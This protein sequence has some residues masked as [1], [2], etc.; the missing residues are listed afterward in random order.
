MLWI[1]W[2]YSSTVDTIYGPEDRTMAYRFTRLAAIRPRVMHSKNEKK[3]NP[4]RVQ[5][6]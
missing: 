3:K 4:N 6:T 1:L 5:Y 2:F